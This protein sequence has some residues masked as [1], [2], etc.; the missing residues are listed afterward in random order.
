MSLLQFKDLFKKVSPYLESVLAKNHMR[1]I[2]RL[3]EG[4]IKHGIM[5]DKLI[6]VGQVLKSQPG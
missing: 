4:A 3:V 1:V 2:V 5:Q 6:K